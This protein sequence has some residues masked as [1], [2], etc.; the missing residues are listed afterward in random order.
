M[1]HMNHQEKGE[2]EQLQEDKSPTAV[3]AAPLLLTLDDYH[4]RAKQLLPK[5]CY[6]Y[7]ASGADQMITLALNE[8]HFQH[9]RLRPRMLVDV[10]HVDT[11]VSLLSSNC[12]ASSS[13]ACPQQAQQQALSTKKSTTTI[14]FPIMIAP[15][16]M[17][18]MAHEHGELATARA[19]SKLGTVF[20]LSSLSTTSMR[21]VA[22]VRRSTC[23]NQSVDGGACGACG[24]A[25][26]WF[27]LYIT[28]DRNLT[29]Q[30]VRNAE[31]YGYG[32]LVLT[33]DAP[34][35]GNR[36]AD[37]HNRFQLPDG[38][39]LVNLMD[40]LKQQGSSSRSGRQDETGHRTESGANVGVNVH[41]LDRE[42]E[43]TVKQ[44]SALNQYFQTQIDASLTWRDIQWLKS[45]TKLPII[46]KGILTAEDAMLAVHYGVQ[47]IVVSN[48]G[49]RQVDTSVSSIEALP[50]VVRMVR[51]LG[52]Q[53][54]IDVYLDGGIRHGTDVLKALAL[55][56]KA[57]FIGRPVIWGLAVAGEQG[58]MDVLSILRRELLLAMQLCGCPD[59]KSISSS[60]LHMPQQSRL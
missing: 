58:V 5:M 2:H 44:S 1:A 19:A 33:V 4:N 22:Q 57:V 8:L 20:T 32:A 31:Q 9:I 42:T 12:A 49:A 13:C 27:Q 38:L 28:K 41:V 53:D 26:Q 7:Y 30:L 43:K 55:G 24:A 16:A 48:H 47:G 60:L 36:L 10:S 52:A 14:P 18:R 46:L 17:Q 39:S 21:D 35:L 11:R 29:R 51:S 15:T 59:V 56:A 6:D 34:K 54:R 25:P 23:E 40:A 50:E 45:L 3:V 37:H